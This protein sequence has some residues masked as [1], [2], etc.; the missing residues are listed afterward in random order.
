MKK[1]IHC[2]THQ[3]ILILENKTDIYGNSEGQIKILYFSLSFT[4]EKHITTKKEHKKILILRKK[5]F[6]TW[7]NKLNFP[8]LKTCFL[9]TNKK[10]YSLG[11]THEKKFTVTNIKENVILK[12]ELLFT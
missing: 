3:K 5:I 1:Q 9:F 6:F 11:W 8:F 12:I 7:L 4:H 10:N 2:Y